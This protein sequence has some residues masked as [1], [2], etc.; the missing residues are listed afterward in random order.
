MYVIFYIIDDYIGNTIF[1]FFNKL[2]SSYYNNYKYD[3]VHNTKNLIR[4]SKKKPQIFFICPIKNIK[5]KL[6][7][8][9][10]RFKNSK[11]IVYNIDQ[12]IYTYNDHLEWTLKIPNYIIWD[13]S[14]LNIEYIKNKYNN[15]KLITKFV[16]LAL[17]CNQLKLDKTKTID[18]LFYGKLYSRRKHLFK[19][20]LQENINAVFSNNLFEK[21]RDEAL[22]I[23]KIALIIS[24]FNRPR[25]YN[26]LFRLYYLV[27][28]NIFTISESSEKNDMYEGITIITEYNNFV[29]TIKKYLKL[30]D[31]ERY[32]IVKTNYEN[33]KKKFDMTKIISKEYL[34]SLISFK[35]K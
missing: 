22:K 26:D 15:Q 23:T 12:I 14:K 13:Y 2:F 18:V 24:R 30:T 34:D 20:L 16:P 28:N 35:N 1:K 32:D 4:Y 5:H 25:K 33:Y 6:L 7:K 17:S 29:D 19:K 3:V 9:I 11:I 10:D 31:E 27:S 8:Y 21:S